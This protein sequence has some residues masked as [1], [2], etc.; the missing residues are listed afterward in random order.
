MSSNA[1]VSAGKPKIGG[2]I[3]VAPA[4][5]ALPTNA[6]TALNVAFYNLGYV[7]EDGL[8]NENST[9]HDNVHAWGG[10]VVACLPGEYTDTYQFTLLEVLSADVQKFVRGNANVTVDTN[11]NMTVKANN[12]ELPEQVIV[13]EMI[14]HGRAVRHVIP[15]GV[16]TE[17]GETEYKDDDAVG[18]EITVTALPDANGNSHYEY[19]AAPSPR[20]YNV[21][22][23]ANGGSVSPGQ[24]TVTAGAAYDGLPTATRSGYTFDG[25]YTSTTGGD[26]ITSTSTV[27]VSAD[28]TLYAHW[29]ES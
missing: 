9:E 22:L 21:R 28:Q 19:Y 25:W 2:A 26:Q 12:Q 3:S 5:T 1:N 8:T 11:G 23:E 24:I 27:S 16:I 7:S 20:T 29:T 6:T 14:L 4:G 15:R 18:Y 13:I 10:D 17:R